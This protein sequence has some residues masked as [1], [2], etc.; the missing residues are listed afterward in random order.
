MKQSLLNIL[1]AVYF[2]PLWESTLLQNFLILGQ[3]EK[4]FI[5]LTPYEAWLYTYNI[6]AEECNRKTLDDFEEV[7]SNEF[8]KMHDK[9]WIGKS[10]ILSK[11]FS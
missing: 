2:L 8:A 5:K 1:H 6:K 10:L 4:A 7:I 11:I 9:V 3:A